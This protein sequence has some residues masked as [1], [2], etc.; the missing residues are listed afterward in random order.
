M[1]DRDRR[2]RPTRGRFIVID[3]GAHGP[4]DE[5]ITDSLKDALRKVIRPRVEPETSRPRRRVRGPGPVHRI[6]VPGA[7]AFGLALG[8]CG[9]DG[10]GPTAEFASADVDLGSPPSTRTDEVV[11]VLH[12]VEVPDPYRWLEEQQASDTRAWI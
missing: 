6:V 7:V 12:G 5:A 9:G 10:A 11:D 2:G 1:T 3:P 8:G 4:S